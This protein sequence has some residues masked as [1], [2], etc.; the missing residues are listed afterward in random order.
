MTIRQG[1]M[2]C[3]TVPDEDAFSFAAEQGFDFVELDMEQAFPPQAIDVPSAER[4]RITTS[5]SSST[6]RIDSTPDL[7]TT[8]FVT[9]RVGNS[10]V[11]SIRR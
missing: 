11:L 5:M 2:A 1:L 9:E 4:W 6:S 7:I 10:N 3:G 8:T